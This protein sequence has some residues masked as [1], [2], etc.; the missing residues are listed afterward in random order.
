MHDNRN[1]YGAHQRWMRNNGYLWLGVFMSA[2]S[3]IEVIIKI[4]TQKYTNCKAL[5]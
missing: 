5:L 1:T 3:H 4:L 2:S